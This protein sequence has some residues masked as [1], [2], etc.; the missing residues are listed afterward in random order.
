MRL[1]SDRRPVPADPA[2]H[3]PS[4]S[5]AWLA[6][7]V[8]MQSAVLLVTA[9]FMITCYVIS[10]REEERRLSIGPLAAEYQKHRA[11]SWRLIPFV[12]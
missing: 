12:Y 5:L 1:H 7:P 2:P 9:I 11:S 6:A 10:A 8:A 4:Y 3:L